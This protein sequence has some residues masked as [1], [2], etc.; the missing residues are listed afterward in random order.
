MRNCFGF[1]LAVVL[2]LCSCSSPLSDGDQGG[3]VITNGYVVMEN[4]E[5]AEGAVVTAYPAELLPPF[6]TDTIL[7][8]S[9]TG[10]DGAFILQTESDLVFNL[11]VI[12]SGGDAGN[13]LY[14]LS[15]DTT[16]GALTLAR[17][18]TLS[19]TVSGDSAAPLSLV[20]GCVGTP[21]FGTVASESGVFSIGNLPPGAYNVLVY[22]PD[23][24][25]TVFFVEQCSE[26]GCSTASDRAPIIVA[27]DSITVIELFLSDSTGS[28]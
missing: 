28:D 11:I 18:G 15:G 1:T 8:Q 14:N 4:G 2:Y 7:P 10:K 21:F 12:N 26:A 22:P 13:V 5:P 20:T 6:P 16:V 25:S 19:G 3:T 9:V 27:S 24:R 23:N 17:F